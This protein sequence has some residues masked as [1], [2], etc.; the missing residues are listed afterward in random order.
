MRTLTASTLLGAWERALSQR[1]AERALT[2]LVLANTELPPERLAA[3][4]FGQRDAH[5]LN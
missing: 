1:P 4:T 5:L 2:L 3:L